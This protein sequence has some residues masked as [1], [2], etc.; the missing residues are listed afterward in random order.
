MGRIIGIVIAVAIVV[1]LLIY[2]GFIQISPEGEAALED[3]QDNVGEAV[4][5]TGEAIQDENT[6]GN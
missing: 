6:D 2:F 5:N 4:E 1:A 3:A